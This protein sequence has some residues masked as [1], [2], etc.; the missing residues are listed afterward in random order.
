M[1]YAVHQKEFIIF[2]V[3]ATVLTDCTYYCTYCSASTALVY[4]QDRAQFIAFFANS[5][6]YITIPILAI[7]SLLVI[8]PVFCAMTQLGDTEECQIQGKNANEALNKVLE[9]ISRISRLSSI[10]QSD[11]I[12]KTGI[13]Q[14]HSF[15]F[16][17]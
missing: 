12:S 6:L 17:T 5:H 1:K 15:K 13:Q 2:S 3:T 7:A 10:G 14:W 16:Y 9:G 4:L 8:S 11:K